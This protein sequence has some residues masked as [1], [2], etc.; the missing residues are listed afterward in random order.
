MLSGVPLKGH[1]GCESC[2]QQSEPGHPTLPQSW[3]EEEE[4]VRKKIERNVEQADECERGQQQMKQSR[5]KVEKY[6][7]SRSM[8]KTFYMYFY[9]HKHK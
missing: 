9:T 3:E 2:A 1:W 8:L 5:K 7:K 4:E 6:K